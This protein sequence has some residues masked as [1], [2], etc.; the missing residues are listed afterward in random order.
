MELARLG[1]VPNAGSQPPDVTIGAIVGTVLL[2][3]SVLHPKHRLVY[4][5]VCHGNA[6]T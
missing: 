2:S 4:D 1:L 5:P 3:N 6:S